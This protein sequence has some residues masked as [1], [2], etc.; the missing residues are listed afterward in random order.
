M[1]NAS[2]YKLDGNVSGKKITN[3]ILR[4]VK[5][6]L[7]WRCNRIFRKTRKKVGLGGAAARRL[8]ESEALRSSRRYREATKKL[9]KAAELAEEEEPY[10]NEMRV[11]EGAL[12]KAGLYTS[13]AEDIKGQLETVQRCLINRE[14]SEAERELTEAKN[15]IRILLESA[16][17]EALRLR[18]EGMSEF[19][20]GRYEEAASVWGNST[21]EFGTVTGIVASGMD[22]NVENKLSDRPKKLLENGD[23]LVALAELSSEISSE[24][25]VDSTDL[26]PRMHQVADGLESGAVLKFVENS[27][28]P[29]EA[30]TQ[31][32]NRVEQ[33]LTEYRKLSNGVEGDKQADVDIPPTAKE[34]DVQSEPERDAEP[35]SSQDGHQQPPTEVTSSSLT[36]IEY[37]KITKQGMVGAGGNADVYRAEYRDETIALKEPRVSGTL[38]TEVAEDIMEE[39]KIWDSI[40]NHDHIV[41]VMD[42]GSQPLPWIAM[43]YM[44]G[45]HLGEK[46]NR[47]GSRQSLW[48]AIQVT[49]AV[50]HAHRKGV[51]HLDIKPEN[52]L[53]TESGDGWDVPK[54]SDWGLSK[55][56]LKHSE[57]VEQVS[58]RYAA[59]EQFDDSYGSSDDLTDVYQLGAVFY[60]MF[61]GQ[62]PFEGNPTSV[63]QS[64]LEDEVTPPS[65]VADVPEGT[66][67]VL[68]K[69]LNKRKE[70]RYESVLFLRDD[71][72]DIYEGL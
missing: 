30:L 53:F 33:I 51:A 24:E 35:F 64:V 48:T 63:M 34:V 54:V 29:D 45:G 32:E 26:S 61:T 65:E 21:E 12:L 62:P 18:K 44:G 43:E 59:P 3:P 42:Y 70:E 41:S 27:E 52:I 60:R 16:I 68:L 20:K 46:A 17:E 56:L 67:E 72:Q 2:Q 4:I 66:D 25:P 9:K 22:F 19:N 37:S 36:S 47:I 55:Q 1:M 14:Y 6:P 69:A 49:Q 11:Y 5:K 57:E 71:L 7:Q 38:H 8:A 58:P 50:H 15:N 13:G 10:L 23:D 28:H 31:F 39:A 40:D